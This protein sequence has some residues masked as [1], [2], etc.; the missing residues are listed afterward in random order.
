[1]FFLVSCGSNSRESDVSVVNY[2]NPIKIPETPEVVSVSTLITEKT[3]KAVINADCDYYI[4]IGGRSGRLLQG[5]EILIG[6]HYYL[7]GRFDVRVEVETVD[8]TVNGYVSERYITRLDDIIHDL[9]FKNV[10]LTREYYYTET[11]ENIFNNDYGKNLRQND[12]VD[13]ER[14]V[15]LWGAFYSEDRLCIFENYL[16]MGNDEDANVYRIENVTNDRNIY[17]LHLTKYPSGEFEITLVDDGNG[18]T[19]TQYVIKKELSLD[20]IPNYLNFRY[21]P[22]DTEKSEKTKA[23]VFAWCDKQIA[24][25]EQINSNN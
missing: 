6:E 5:Q 19:M 7:S 11:V 24:I 25:L 16:A 21:V 12:T 10:L 13:K 15:R 1:M 22:Q 9:W 17:T 8:G 20:P 2:Q 3:N 23:A 4:Q 14:L 18:I